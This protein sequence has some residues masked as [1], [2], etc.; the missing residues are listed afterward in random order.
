MT[1]PIE[2][3]KPIPG[4]YEDRYDIS[5][6]GRI[7]GWM[8]TSLKASVPMERR[9]LTEPRNIAFFLS[10][11]KAKNRWGV[12][13]TNAK[14]KKR[15]LLVHHLVL[16][17]FVGPRPS[18]EI[19]ACHNNGDAFDNRLENLR[20]DTPSANSLDLVK[21]GNHYN[22]RKTH[23][24]RGHELTPENTYSKYRRCL[25][26]K[27]EYDKATH[28]ANRE[29]LNAAR[30]ERYYRSKERKKAQENPDT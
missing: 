8:K 19:H 18:P 26:C 3:W 2:V 24:K 6:L 22:A 17:A 10:G 9:R 4:G 30:N 5:N 12:R 13:L 25:I 16:E 27:K 21:H 28:S 23:C 1:D 29:A 11:G 7:R 14:G 20:W 15:S